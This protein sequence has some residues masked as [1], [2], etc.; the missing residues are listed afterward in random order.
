MVKREVTCMTQVKGK[1]HSR[2]EV[3]FFKD[4]Y[5]IPYFASTQMS[6]EKGINNYTWPCLC[7]CGGRAVTPPDP[8]SL[9]LLILLVKGVCITVYMALRCVPPPRLMALIGRPCNLLILPPQ[10]SFPRYG[11]IA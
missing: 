2:W 5:Q 7:V 4:G 8:C 3:I 9:E 1:S 10:S 6:L 11:V